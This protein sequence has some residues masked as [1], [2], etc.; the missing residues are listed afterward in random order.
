VQDRSV[1]LRITMNGAVGAPFGMFP[2][3]ALSVPSGRQFGHS[4]SVHGPIKPLAGACQVCRLIG[5]KLVPDLH[6]HC[7]SF[8]WRSHRAR[9]FNL[10]AEVDLCCKLDLRHVNSNCRN[11]EWNPRSKKVRPAVMCWRFTTLTHTPS[12]TLT[13]A[14]WCSDTLCSIPRPCGSSRGSRARMRPFIKVAR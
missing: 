1:S 13:I 3:R 9:L 5:L 6:T 7:M 10:H 2:S 11:T 14:S 8:E 12:L 4:S